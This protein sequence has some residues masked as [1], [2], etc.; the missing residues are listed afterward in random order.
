MQKQI[1][2]NYDGVHTPVMVSFV[3]Y[4]PLNIYENSAVMGV[5]FAYVFKVSFF[6]KHAKYKNDTFLKVIFRPEDFHIVM[7][8]LIYFIFNES[9]CIQ[10]QKFD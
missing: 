9:S 8:V 5:H 6:T 4:W 10:V 1:I 3:I 2:C 7:N